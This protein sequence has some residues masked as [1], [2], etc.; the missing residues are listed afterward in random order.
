[1][2]ALKLWSKLENAGD[3]TSPQLGT[4]GSEIGS[5]TYVASKFN[6]GIYSDVDD[7]GCSFPTGANS[8][9]LDK[10]TIEFW[11]K[12]FYNQ[13]DAG[14]H[15]FFDLFDTGEGG[16]VLRFSPT[17]DDFQI[18]VYSGDVEIVS[19]FTVGLS[20]ISGDIW[21]FGLTW[22]REGNDIGG[23]KTVALYINNVEVASSITGWDTDDV[24][25]NIYIGIRR[26]GGYHSDMVIDNLKTLDTC[27]TDFSDKD[28]ED[29]GANQAPTAP[30]SLQVDG[31]SSPIGANCVSDLTPSLSAI[32]NDPDA[33]DESNAIAIEVGSA[34]GLSDL[35]DSGWLADT[36]TE[37]NRCNAKNYAGAA[38][39]AGTSYWWR[40]RF[41]DDDDTEGAWSAWQQFDVCAAE[42][43]EE[44]GLLECAPGGP[45][46]KRCPFR[47]AVALPRRVPSWLY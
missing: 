16:I 29:A 26:A 14:W 12:F 38:L 40:C 34:S 8:I 7:E 20:W 18:L 30:T 36:T 46:P 2:A 39:S 17:E 21:H 31:E 4:G 11:V 23:G 22:D 13:F 19:I 25:A 27:K 1:M 24:N 32:F 47:C 15:Y 6:N 9:N 28:V 42:P 33:G 44:A 10:C 45:L 43:E 5:P 37:G 3:V 35:W 41:R